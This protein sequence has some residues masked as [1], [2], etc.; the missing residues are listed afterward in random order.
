MLELNSPS[1]SLKTPQPFG[2]LLKG[3]KPALN[4]AVHYAS[5]GLLQ[6]AKDALDTYEEIRQFPEDVDTT[7]EGYIL[8]Y[9]YYCDHSY[10]EQALALLNRIVDI[11]TQYGRVDYFSAAT[12]G[13]GNLCEIYGKP[14]QAL[15]FYSIVRG[16]MPTIMDAESA[17]QVHL[18]F[19]SCCI[20][21]NKRHSAQHHLERCL[22][23]SEQC[24]QPVYFNSILYYQAVL[25]RLNGN[26]R[27]ALISLSQISHQAAQFDSIWLYLE[28]KREVAN[29]LIEANRPELA[30]IIMEKCV[31]Y[32]RLHGNQNTLRRMLV[33]LSLALEA[34][35]QFEHALQVEKQI[36]PIEMQTISRIPISELGGYTLRK[37][38]HCEIQIKLAL[39]EQ[40][41]A[42]LIEHSR[43][44]KH[45]MQALKKETLLDPL[46]GLYNR[47]WLDATL[48][49][50]NAFEQDI[51]IVILDIDYFK[52]INDTHSHLAGDNVL[53]QIATIIKQQFK[54]FHC[55]RFGGEEFIIVM[56]DTS[57]ADAYQLTEACRKAI[58]ASPWCHILG[59][60]GLTVSAGIA[61]NHTNMPI[62]PL[63][64]DADAALYKAKNNGRNQ[65]CIYR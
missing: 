20:T 54:P 49:Q 4:D 43:Q 11:A 52:E 18:H 32:A 44:Q 36:L 23:L 38:Y 34:S 8:I 55:C 56:P 45:Q 60:Q 58:S 28:S 33:T 7:F 5:Q 15:K 64:Q 25:S 48:L 14:N 37:L 41:N 29:C 53:R 1:P 9:Q 63:L 46:T 40:K 61:S 65:T 42:E 57:Q 12:I 2:P 27:Q 3:N 17:L 50:L 62:E 35:G 24:K 13:M 26:K 51:T 10:Y 16:L 19:L 31:Y 6:Q 21:L 30:Q 39:S 59:E 47:R 22:E